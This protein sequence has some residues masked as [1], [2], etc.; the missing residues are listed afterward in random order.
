MFEEIS[1]FDW[2]GWGFDSVISLI[3]F[4]IH[5]YLILSN[6]FFRLFESMKSAYKRRWSSG[7]EMTFLYCPASKLEAISSSDNKRIELSS[8]Y[9][10]QEGM[11]SNSFYCPQRDLIEYREK[12]ITKERGKREDSSRITSS[13]RVLLGS[14]LLNIVLAWSIS[15]P[16][17]E[18]NW[19]VSVS[20]ISCNLITSS[21]TRE[22]DTSTR[23]PIVRR[24]NS[25][26]RIS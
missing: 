20:L 3:Y 23:A 17:R 1:I 25:W 4:R 18:F 7:G 16:I 21:N 10:F 6:K 26:G 22:K 9:F 19:W 11:Y 12:T 2:H 24:K 8:W 14:F 13:A 5:L 15:K